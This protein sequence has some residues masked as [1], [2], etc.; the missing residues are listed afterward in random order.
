MNPVV[1]RNVAIG[2]GIPKICVPIVGKTREEILEAAKNILPIGADVVEWR[3]DWYEDIFDF[4]KVEETAKQLREVLGEMPILF[5]FRT[6]KEGGEKAIPAEDK[7]NYFI[8]NYTDFAYFTKSISGLSD[9]DKVAAKANLDGYAAA[10]ND[11]SRTMEQV[12]EEYKTAENLST[13]PLQ[14]DVTNLST[15]KKYVQSYSE[16]VAALKEMQTGKARVVE[17]N[18][19]YMLVVKND[20]NATADEKLKDESVELQVLAALKEQEYITDM[21]ALV[22]SYTDYTLH[23]DVMNKFDPAVFEQSSDTSS[24]ESTPASS[25]VSEASEDTTSSQTTT[26]N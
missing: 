15:N 12:A 26:S 10:I 19:S 1:V 17:T 13:N 20:I 6:S 8:E 9:E 22:E 4:E 2:E 21:N 7:K 16:M 11:G 24:A 18:S 3:V 23:E 25:A 14:S 5:T